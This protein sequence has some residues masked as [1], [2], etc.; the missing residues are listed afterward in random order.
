MGC[1]ATNDRLAESLFGTWDYKLRRCPG[2]SMEAACALVQAARAKSFE[3]GG[4]F[5]TL[6]PLEAAALVEMARS[7]VREM[8]II[9]RADH[10]SLD[11]Y[12]TAK[13]KS[14][15]QLELD[16]L[17]KRYALALSFFDRWRKRGVE[18]VVA[19][20]AALRDI[21]T[22]Q[23]KLDYL[24][25]QIEMR[26]I[27]LGFD[28]FK[29]AWSSGKDEDIGTVADLT[30]S[31]HEILGE[32]QQRRRKGE[33]P[34][35]A[36]VPQMRRKTFKMLGTPTVQAAALADK[37]LELPVEKLLE[38]AE[39]ERER[40]EDAGELD[41]VGDNQPEK[42]PRCDDALIGTKLE[43]RWRYWAKV[44]DPKDKRKKQ[45]VDIWTEGEVVQ[46][47]NGTTDTESP[48]CRKLVEAGA[49]RIKWAADAAFEEEESY[50]WS[51]L[52]DDN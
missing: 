20:T 49:V 22:S 39:R 5:H 23:L 7:S 3:D 36:V 34:E 44:T 43:V 41:G 18:T 9:D 16:A 2:I 19:V 28:E 40:L 1:D 10:A 6:P 37:V 35:A 17:V 14:N 48:R 52:R 46:I 24:R 33:L 32:E 45:A 27:G 21:S 12:H 25:E 50:T 30:E 42:P 8:R 15:S 4:Y 38:R 26:V 31:L 29:A 51:I 11:A 13:R 47:A